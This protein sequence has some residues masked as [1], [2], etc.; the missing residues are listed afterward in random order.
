V[1]DIAAWLTVKVSPAA[2]I[3][4]ERGDVDVLAA[5]LNGTVPFPF[6][7][8]APVSVIQ[9][10]AFDVAVHAHPLATLTPTLPVAAPAPTDWLPAVNVGAHVGENEKPFDRALGVDPPGPIAVTRASNTTPGVG[11]V[12]KSGRKS[13]RMRLL[14]GLGF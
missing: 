1:H 2:V 5:T 11:T 14:D 9:L 13:T 8:V 7:L 12:C 3:V 6:P 4:P 10:G